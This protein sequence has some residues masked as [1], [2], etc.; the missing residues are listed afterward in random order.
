MK[1][2]RGQLLVESKY[3][4]VGKIACNGKVIEGVRGKIDNDARPAIEEDV[5]KDR[6]TKQTNRCG[7]NR[8]IKLSLI[9]F[10]QAF[11]SRVD[12]KIYL[13]QKLSQLSDILAKPKEISYHPSRAA[14]FY[15]CAVCTKQA[16]VKRS[17]RVLLISL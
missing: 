15:P 3:A 9:H 13:V 2:I 7:N 12:E 16:F 14:I 17:R 1:P 6:Q 5:Q 8:L 11:H 4:L 10:Y